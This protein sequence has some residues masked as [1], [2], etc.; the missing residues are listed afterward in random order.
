MDK[1]NFYNNSSEYFNILKNEPAEYYDEFI[2]F[3]RYY[4]NNKQG[5]IL[6]VGCGT[7]QSTNY[8]KEVGYQPVGYDFSDRY[9]E[10]AKKNY[11]EIEFR[12]GAAEKM[13][14]GDN[15]FS[16]VVT[17]N[18]I[19]HFDDI[20]GS[21]S[22]MNRVLKPGGLLIIQ[23]PNLLSPK[24]PIASIRKNGQTFEGQKN[25]FELLHGIIQFLYRLINNC[26]QGYFNIIYQ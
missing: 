11:P 4:L 5:K 7:G 26:Q 12:Q 14:F 13:P 16:A 1:F 25:F 23:A 19:E 20:T 2:Q 18:S 22:E 3:V 6:D 17:Y 8:L 15:E 9:I 21:L 24:L 10:H